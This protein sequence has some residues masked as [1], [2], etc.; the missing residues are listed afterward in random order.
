MIY[1]A[2]RGVLVYIP[3][4]SVTYQICCCDRRLYQ[5][6]SNNTNEYMLMMMHVPLLVVLLVVYQYMNVSYILLPEN[7]FNEY[8]K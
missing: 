5:L 4:L 8:L 3:V 6:H 1:L 2:T 7:E